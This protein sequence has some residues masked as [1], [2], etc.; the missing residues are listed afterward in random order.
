MLPYLPSNGKIGIVAN[1]Q[2]DEKCNFDI[3]EMFVRTNELMT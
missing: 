1:T 3:F 2:I